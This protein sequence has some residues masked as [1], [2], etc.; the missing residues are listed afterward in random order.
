MMRECVVLIRDGKVIVAP[1]FEMSEVPELVR[2][3]ETKGIKK[4]AGRDERRSDT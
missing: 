3:G 2:I 1:V 4:R